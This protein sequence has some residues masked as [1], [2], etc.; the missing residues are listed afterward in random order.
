[1]LEA[2]DFEDFNKGGSSSKVGSG[3]HYKC[4]LGVD[5]T[6]DTCFKLYT[7]ML[8]CCCIIMMFWCCH[9]L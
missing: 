5:V 9:V 1:M 4:R 7:V 3:A 8:L 6:L 2:A